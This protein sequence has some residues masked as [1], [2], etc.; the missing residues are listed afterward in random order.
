MFQLLD[1]HPSAL[2]LNKYWWC[3][4]KDSSKEIVSGTSMLYQNLLD[5]DYIQRTDLWKHG[6]IEDLKKYVDRVTNYDTWNWTKIG[7]SEAKNLNDL[8][9]IYG[10]EKFIEEMI[11]R[12]GEEL[13]F[14][15]TDT[16][17]L[18]LKIEEDKKKIYIDNK[19]KSLIKKGLMLP[20]NELHNV[21]LV[22]A[23][24]YISELGNQLAL[25]NTDLDFIIIINL[26]NQ[27]VSYRGIKDNINLGQIA[28]SFGGG[29]HVKASG[30]QIK[31]EVI[32]ELLDSIFSRD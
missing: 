22:F 24:Q 29:G 16:D 19:N 17:N 15:F 31:D 28:E 14:Y 25:L 32:D 10:R 21:G 1:H 11:Y 26:G 30:S 6:K 27:T 18:I 23:E 9:Y 2:G 20:N 7:D 4:V 8:F 12:L 13:S 5:S 3:Q